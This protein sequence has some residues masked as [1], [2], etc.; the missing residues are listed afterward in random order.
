MDNKT[1]NA[2]VEIFKENSR[3]YLQCVPSF[4]VY[5]SNYTIMSPRGIMKST[6]QH[7]NL[8]SALLNQLNRIHS[9]DNKPEFNYF[10]VTLDG[11]FVYNDFNESKTGYNFTRINMIA[12]PYIF[13]NVDSN[14]DHT[15][16]IYPS[17]FTDNEYSDSV[18]R[19]TNEND[20][21]RVNPKDIS[22]YHLKRMIM[23]HKGYESRTA[24]SPN[25]CAILMNLNSAMIH[26]HL[27]I[28]VTYKDQ[29]IKCCVA[30][31]IIYPTMQ[32]LG[33]MDRFF[34]QIFKSNLSV[35]ALMIS[36]YH[37]MNLYR[38]H[39]FNLFA[40]YLIDISGIISL[41]EF[42]NIFSIV[43]ELIYERKEKKDNKSLLEMS[44]ITEFN[45]SELIKF[46]NV[47][48]NSNQLPNFGEKYLEENCEVKVLNDSYIIELV[49]KWIRGHLKWANEV[50]MSYFL[51]AGLNEETFAII[52]SNESSNYVIEAQSYLNH[53]IDVIKTSKEIFVERISL[54][55][56]KPKVLNKNIA[57]LNRILSDILNENTQN[58]TQLLN[59][60]NKAILDYFFYAV[61]KYKGSL[62]GIHNQFGKFSFLQLD[63]IKNHYH[64][65][66][67]EKYELLH[68]YIHELENIDQEY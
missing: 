65:S 35:D 50:F 37:M 59:Q 60:L 5:G 67:N 47:M 13:Y 11:T 38:D 41:S 48:F 26:F 54:T 27:V 55:F 33:I 51:F 40:Y 6:K 29:I 42:K 3:F 68:D 17:L 8:P 63:G 61:W 18:I 25:N 20:G 52:E 9:L 32:K 39:Y 1:Y 34:N 19:D 15:T 22:E 30:E 16:Y 64:C 12:H 66:N 62:N 24:L 43:M 31:Y 28:F 49:Q 14:K 21:L 45:Y 10:H 53:W 7:S 23:I 58:E 57:I 2:D 46:I 56:H 44:F 4:G 36:V